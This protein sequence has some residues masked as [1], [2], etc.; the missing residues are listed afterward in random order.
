MNP[1][2]SDGSILSAK[3]GKRSRHFVERQ[4]KRTTS[5]KPLLE[6]DGCDGEAS[7]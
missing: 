6:E 5:M 4:I 1:L 7:E 3:I 2:G